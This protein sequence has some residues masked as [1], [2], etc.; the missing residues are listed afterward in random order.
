MAKASPKPAPSSAKSKASALKVTTS[1][2]MTPA[3]KRRLEEIASR[4]GVSQQGV[5]TRALAE[6]FDKVDRRAWGTIDPDDHYDPHRYYTFGS[7]QKGHS[8]EIRI[9][10]P[11][12]LRG[13]MQ[14][15]VESG[16]IPEYRTAQ[17][18]A[19]DALYHRIK[20]LSQQIDND[21]LS[22]AVGLAML[23]SD[24]E[25]IKAT[26]LEAR[27]YIGMVTDNLRTLMAQA[28]EAADYAR[29]REYISDR[30]S[31]AEV[32]P[33]AYRAE[34]EGVLKE[35]RRLVRRASTD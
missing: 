9:Q 7:D 3:M 20:Q 10:I 22:R 12:P 29:V 8:S 25:Q 31:Y 13:E 4:E 2:Q 35:Y 17:H 14:Q 5:V 30:S 6:H 21:E 11:K 1:V 34:Y 18:I 33:E 23:I 15:L 28:H 24:E 32:L 26:D 19:R 27:S 16:A